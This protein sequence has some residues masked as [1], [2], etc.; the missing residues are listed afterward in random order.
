MSKLCGL[1]NNLDI[2]LIVEGHKFVLTEASPANQL[3]THL[4]LLD[5]DL[6]ARKGQMKW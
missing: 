3:L 2:L 1:E 4:R 5:S 6:I